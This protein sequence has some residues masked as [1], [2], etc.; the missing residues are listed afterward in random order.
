MCHPVVED[1]GGD[2]GTLSLAKCNKQA[3]GQGECMANKDYSVIDQARKGY[4]VAGTMALVA[5]QAKNNP[6]CNG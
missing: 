5:F 2:G 4:W 6:T 1:S 3:L